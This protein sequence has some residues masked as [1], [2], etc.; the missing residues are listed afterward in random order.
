ME[1]F[2]DFQCPACKQLFTSTTQ[3][4]MN[5]YVNTG[6]L[7]GS[8]RLSFPYFP[9]VAPAIPFT[10]HWQDEGEVTLQNQG[11]ET[12]GKVAETVAPF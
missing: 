11:G 12:N 10:A 1:V 4:V 7:Y 5:D 8:S 6:N 2:S 3:R 9:R